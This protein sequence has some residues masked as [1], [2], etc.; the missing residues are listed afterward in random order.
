IAGDRNGRHNL[1]GAP[2]LDPVLGWLFAV[3]IFWSVVRIADSRMTLLLMWLAGMLSA[4]IL[5]LDFEAP[6]GARAFGATAALALIAALPLQRLADWT[7]T[8]AA[9][10][11]RARNL[12]GRPCGPPNPLAVATLAAAFSASAVHTWNV[13][14]RLQ[15]YEFASWISFST[16]ETRI[17]E[18]VRDE[19]DRPGQP[20]DVY[21]PP[22]LLGFP[23]ETFLLGHPLDVMPPF[24]VGGVLNPI[25]FQGFQ[26]LPFRPAGRRV[27]LF[28]GPGESP[29]VPLVRR[30]YPR[31]PI[32]RFGPPR[33][34]GAIGE[35][36]A[37][38]IVRVAP[39]DVEAAERSVP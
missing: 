20:A 7:G 33:P 2:M 24:R 10:R 11:G 6:Q 30:Y 16:M 27:I 21:V 17:A 13:F 4:G 29:V 39:A 32:E 23:T 14:F 12:S 9:A 18:V 28:L 36:T 8:A 22:G 38:W 19:V 26:A 25:R 34:D 35:P 37:L 15:P 1:P 31:A 3:G 5:S